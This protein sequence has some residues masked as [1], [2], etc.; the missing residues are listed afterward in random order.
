MCSGVYNG[1]MREMCPVGV[2]MA[3]FVCSTNIWTC[4]CR[5]RNSSD[6]ALSL[7]DQSLF[8]SQFVLVCLKG[9]L[10]GET[11]SSHWLALS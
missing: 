3:S 5:L 7:F 2:A 1:K 4:L 9:T 11:E 6:D 10:S 8:V